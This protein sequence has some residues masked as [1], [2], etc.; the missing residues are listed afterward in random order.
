MLVRDAMSV[1]VETIMPS[2]TIQ[3]CARKMKDLNVGALPVS[4]EGKL[5]GLVTDR[6]VCCRGVGNSLDP[7]TALVRDIM[8]RGVT[9]CFTDQDLG[10]AAHIM[11][12]KHVRRLTVMNRD[13]TVAGILSVDDLARYSH[14]LAGEIIDATSPQS[15]VG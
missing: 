6:D 4:T 7:K 15:R 14:N 8:T 2:A 3:D 12:E 10:A 13:N 11:E 1:M 5:V 9:S